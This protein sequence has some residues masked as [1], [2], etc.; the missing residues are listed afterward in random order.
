[1]PSIQLFEMMAHE[2]IK[3]LNLVITG[4]PSTHVSNHVLGMNQLKF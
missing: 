4:M 2:G 1:M 3:V